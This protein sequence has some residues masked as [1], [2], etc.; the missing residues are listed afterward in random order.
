[1]NFPT[2]NQPY[3]RPSSPQQ[4]KNDAFDLFTDYMKKEDLIKLIVGQ[5]PSWQLSEL[6]DDHLMGRI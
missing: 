1:M 6:I 5:L 2:F 4:V 3:D